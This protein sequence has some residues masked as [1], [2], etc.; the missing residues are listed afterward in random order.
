MKHFFYSILSVFFSVHVSGQS[1]PVVLIHFTKKDTVLL[2]WAPVNA[3][4]MIESLNKGYTIERIEGSGSFENNSS[5]VT[6]KIEPFEKRKSVYLESNDEKLREFAE[7]IEG[8]LS[9]SAESAESAQM[10]YGVL[11]LGTSVDIDLAQIL[12][13][14]YIDSETGS[15]NYTYRVRISGSETISNTVFLNSSEITVDKSMTQ[16]GGSSRPKLKQT[17][18]SWE[19]HSLEQ[20]YAAFWIERSTDSVHF[21]R[22]NKNPYFFLKSQDEP[23]KTI[24]DYVDTNVQ[25]GQVYYY[26]ITGINH[27]AET[28]KS[29]NIVKVYVPRSL[30]GEIHIDSVSANKSE[31]KIDGAFVDYRSNNKI[32]KFVL[33]RSDSSA[34]GYSTIAE[35][36]YLTNSFSFNSTVPVE[37]GDRYYYKVAAISPDNDTVYS[38]PYY[39]FTLDQI[40]PAV[41]TGLNGLINETGIVNLHWNLNAE[42][43]IRGYRVYRSNSLK[44]EFVEVTKHFSVNGIFTDTIALNNLTSEIYY[45]VSAVDL[46]YNNSKTCEPVK[47]AKPDTIAPVQA[48]FTDYLSDS[49]G[50]YL[51]WNNSSSTDVKQSLLIR[52][53]DSEKDTLMQWSDT[54]SSFVDST[55]TSGE[56]YSYSILTSDYS[57]NQTASDLLNVNYETGVRTGVSDIQSAVNRELKQIEL[58]WKLPEQEIYSIQIYRAKNDGPFTLYK[59][60]RDPKALSFIDKDLSMNNTYRYKLKVIYKSGISSVLSDEISVTY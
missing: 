51:A 55:G 1:S 8:F 40:P 2:R 42:N 47:L 45:S 39:F 60:L 15:S 57:M 7:L 44:E 25:E 37:S 11:M 31:R 58:T 10:L 32:T 33:L 16:L 29:S 21:E 24:C 23:N 49:K 6:W 56:K 3:D 28:G 41:P 50:V 9:G 35:Q 14:F 17:Y 13:C 5:L 22:R 19:A 43:D 46:N 20:E 26:R 18:L 27:F 30:Y 12:G 53:L 38:F 36:D 52:Q 4:L 48:V 59:T 54:T 34:H